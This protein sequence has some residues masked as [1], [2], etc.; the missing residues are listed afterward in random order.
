MENE[1]LPED[2]DDFTKDIFFKLFGKAPEDIDSEEE[3]DSI[4]ENF[5][6]FLDN[7]DSIF[8]KTLNNIND[9]GDFGEESGVFIQDLTNKESKDKFN[10]F[11]D[12]NGME[13]TI[14]FYKD[15]DIEMIKEDWKNEDATININKVYEY[16]NLVLEVLDDFILKEIYSK[17]LDICINDEEYEEAAILRDK[18][19]NLK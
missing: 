7:Y 9:V 14:S 17:K 10:K 16:D 4:K 12:E 1:E 11:I 3:L 6:I 13:L 19:N 2:W 5:Q 15:V 8:D 18:L